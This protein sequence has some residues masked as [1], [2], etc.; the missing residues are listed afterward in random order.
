MQPSLENTTKPKHNE[1]NKQN[2]TIT[3]TCTQTKQ[4]SIHKVHNCQKRNER[5]VI[6]KFQQKP[7]GDFDTRSYSWWPKNTKTPVKHWFILRNR[8]N[9]VLI[10]ENL[11]KLLD[12]GTCKKFMELYQ[13]H[14]TRI[15]KLLNYKMT[16]HENP[17]DGCI[18]F[19]IN[20]L[21]AKLSYPLQF[22]SRTF[23]RQHTK[24]QNP[25]FST[26]K[27]SPNNGQLSF[28]TI[29]RNQINTCLLIPFIQYRSILSKNCIFT[30]HRPLQAEPIH[31]DDSPEEKI[32]IY[33]PPAIFKKC[34]EPVFFT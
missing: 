15:I 5:A 13:D 18:N 19:S 20:N 34:D 27:I 8:V 28:A 9:H 26:A 11:N 33:G 29:E 12:T 22:Y 3:Q 14:S 1:L 4:T 17:T 2:L 31:H 32:T 21:D 16:N 7:S 30:R 10:Q 25:N 6:E 23:S 24:Y